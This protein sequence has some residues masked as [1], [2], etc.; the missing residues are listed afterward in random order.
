MHHPYVYCSSSL[1]IPTLTLEANKMPKGHI[2]SVY[3]HEISKGLT[4]T[5]LPLIFA[6]CKHCT[7]IDRGLGRK[8]I[9]TRVASKTGLLSQTECITTPKRNP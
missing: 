1:N 6:S 2:L 9:T 5:P 3:T 4:L 8:A 7:F